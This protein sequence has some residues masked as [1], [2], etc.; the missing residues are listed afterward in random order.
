MKNFKLRWHTL[1]SEAT[2][3]NILEHME[4]ALTKLQ[5]EVDAEREAT[6]TVSKET[7]F[8]WWNAATALRDLRETNAVFQVMH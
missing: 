1:K 3:G 8:K 2:V 6:G 7:A 5:A 4:A